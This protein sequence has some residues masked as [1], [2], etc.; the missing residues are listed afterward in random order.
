MQHLYAQRTVIP[1]LVIN[2]CIVILPTGPGEPVLLSCPDLSGGTF[3]APQGSLGDSQWQSGG[4][5]LEACS[6]LLGFGI[7]AQLCTSSTTACPV[8]ASG[9]LGFGNTLPSSLSL[10]PPSP[11]RCCFLHSRPLLAKPGGV[12]PLG[13]PGVLT[14]RSA[15]ESCGSAHVCDPESICACSNDD[16]SSSDTAASLLCAG[17]VT[18]F[19]T[20]KI[21][22]PSAQLCKV[23]VIISPILLV[24][25]KTHSIK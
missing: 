20:H 14:V 22:Q 1:F 25:N 18:S 9:L 19:F 3:T 10:Q 5:Q 7:L 21:S 2:L 16:G 15:S 4:Q 24:R 11:S 17:M 6:L 12:R 13:P 23:S 8:C